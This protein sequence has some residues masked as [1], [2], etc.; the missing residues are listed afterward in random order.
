VSPPFLKVVA[1]FHFLFS[2]LV[3][4]CQEVSSRIVSVSRV[5]LLCRFRFFNLPVSFHNL[6]DFPPD[7][8][9]DSES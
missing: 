6:P 2:S 4:V 1:G 9:R 5:Y 7:S 8:Y 3:T